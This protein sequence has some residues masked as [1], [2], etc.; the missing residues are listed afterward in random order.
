[1]LAAVNELLAS[2][3]EEPLENLESTP[4]SA[5]TARTVLEGV[6]RDFQE[7]GFWF[8]REES[9]VLTPDANGFIFLPANVL[10]LTADEATIVERGDRIYDRENQTFVFTGPLSFT[11]IL[12]LPWD[13]LPS[14]ARRYV[15]AMSIEKFVDGFPGANAVTEARAR[16]LQRAKVAFERA[17]IRNEGLNLLNNSTIQQLTQR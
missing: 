12:H 7:E 11:V 1:M 14:A 16:N 6:S 2:I 5:N 3:G 9:Y 15:T 13:E 8:N 10:S 17:V 4:P